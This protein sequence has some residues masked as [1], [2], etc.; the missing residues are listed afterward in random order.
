MSRRVRFYHTIDIREG[1]TLPGRYDHRPFVNA[2]GF[3]DVRGKSV[4]DVGRASG[5]FSFHFERAGAQSVVAIDLPPD[6]QKNVVGLDQ[7]D[8]GADVGRLDFFLPHALLKSAVKP[9]WLDVADISPETVGTGYDLAFVGSLLIHLA[10]PMGV[11]SKVRK[12]MAPDGVCVI[13]NPI[14]RAEHILSYVIRK[15]LATLVGTDSKTA[16]WLPNIACL[17]LMCLRAGFSRVEL[18]TRNL[19]LRRRNGRS[20]VRHAVVHAW[21]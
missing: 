12:V 6:R 2:Y 10:D 7:G 9:L 5:F 1:L 18:K 13:A 4:L 17:K 11:L 21:P 20:L 16:W 3:P 19:P 8:A 14:G 15:P